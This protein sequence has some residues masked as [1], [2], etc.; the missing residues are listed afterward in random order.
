MVYEHNTSSGRGGRN[1]GR[2]RGS[3]RSSGRG[4][5]SERGRGG[6]DGNKSG[7]NHDKGKA[8]KT[9]SFKGAIES[10]QGNIF[11]YGSL[12]H[13]DQY[14]KTVEAIVTY[15]GQN[16]DAPSLV[17]ESIETE[18]LCEPTDPTEPA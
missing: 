16:F 10:L 14:P 9:K 5:S 12:N 18:K 17:M 8:F 13:R 7:K 4:S 1:S 6:K 3:G 11:E 15:I 2:V